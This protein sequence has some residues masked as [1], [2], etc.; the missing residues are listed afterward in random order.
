VSNNQRYNLET[1]FLIVT[2][3]ELGLSL[4]QRADCTAL[5]GMFSCQCQYSPKMEQDY[6]WRNPRSA[7]QTLWRRFILSKYRKFSG[8]ECKCN[9]I[10]ADFHETHKTPDGQPVL[11]SCLE[12]CCLR[13]SPAMT[14]NKIG[15]KTQN[16]PYN[17]TDT[18]QYSTTVTTLSVT[19]LTTALCH[20]LAIS[21]AEFGL[22]LSR[23]MESAV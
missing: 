2:A 13:A 5:S 10:Y 23:N 12:I 14:A 3:P 20:N 1:F 17:F 18:L 11:C 9:F 21:N 19:T 7:T 16:I 6:K 22:T 15:S 8:Y 4:C